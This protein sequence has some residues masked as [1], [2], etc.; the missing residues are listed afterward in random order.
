MVNVAE[1]RTKNH[2]DYRDADSNGQINHDSTFL[3][4]LG[5]GDRSN[6]GNEVKAAINTKRCTWDSNRH[7]DDKVR[8]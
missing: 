2:L 8:S 5:R 4:G 3:F 1:E 7:G 6:I